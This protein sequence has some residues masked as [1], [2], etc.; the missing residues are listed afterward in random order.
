MDGTLAANQTKLSIVNQT[1]T[2]WPP[3]AALWLLWVMADSTGKAQGLAI[4]DLSFSALDTS[5][6]PAPELGVVNLTGG[7][8]TLAWP[9]V[10][11]ALYRV[12]YK[13]DLATP[14]WAAL[15]NDIP[16]TGAPVSLDLDLSTSPQRFYRVMVVNGP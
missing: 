4:D 8:L 1:I 6:V 11:G 16:G 14:A 5:A 12:Q 10:P 2:N 13:D 3:G 15:G 7:T 9:S